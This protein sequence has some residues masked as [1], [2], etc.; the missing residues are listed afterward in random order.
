MKITKLAFS[1]VCLIELVVLLCP[2]KLAH[3][4]ATRDF[5]SIRSKVIAVSRAYMNSK[6]IATEDYAFQV[7]FVKDQDPPQLLL[8]TFLAPT[9]ASK[10]FSA[11]REDL[12]D[13]VA[14]EYSGP[15]RI[16]IKRISKS[17]RFRDNAVEDLEAPVESLRLAR[18]AARVVETAKSAQAESK[19]SPVT[20]V[21]LAVVAILSAANLLRGKLSQLPRPRAFA[22][23]RPAL[24]P[25]V[26]IKSPKQNTPKP[27]DTSSTVS[28]DRGIQALED[29][30][31]HLA[32]SHPSLSEI[33]LM[34]WAHTPSKIQHAAVLIELLVKH[35]II[36]DDSNIQRG[37][38]RLAKNNELYLAEIS[39]DERKKTLNDIYWTCLSKAFQSEFQFAPALEDKYISNIIN[40]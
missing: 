28:A 19:S 26:E 25:N 14:R 22:L 20:N 13:S 7:N 16:K 12:R 17:P 24:Q 35:K 8:E 1:I 36:L 15:I 5:E 37:M 4:A 9:I 38:S 10:K 2:G 34:Q 31:V 18:T 39:P 3:A 27:T 30:I 23:K 11:M 29:Q 21:L 40:T 32:Q 6:S 33:V